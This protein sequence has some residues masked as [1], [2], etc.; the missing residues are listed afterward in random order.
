MNDKKTIKFSTNYP[1]NTKSL[2][3]PI[4]ISTRG[5]EPSKIENS[6]F[7]NNTNEENLS[8][9]KLNDNINNTNNKTTLSNSLDSIDEN[10]NEVV[11]KILDTINKNSLRIFYDS[12]SEFKNKI[13]SLNLKFYLKTEKYLCNQIRR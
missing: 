3:N 6:S 12:E 5:A 13:D 7:Q 8:I 9:K 4:K 1:L 10:S 11:A 2:N